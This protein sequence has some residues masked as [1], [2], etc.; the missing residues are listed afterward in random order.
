MLIF[1]Y[2]LYSLVQ[3]HEEVKTGSWNLQTAP[4]RHLTSS[5]V[6]L[7]KQ[8]FKGK[9]YMFPLHLIDQRFEIFLCKWP[10]KSICSALWALCHNCS[11][12]PLKQKSSY[13][14]Y[15]NKWAGSSNKI[16]FTKI[17]SQ[18]LGHSLLKPVIGH[19]KLRGSKIG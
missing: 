8:N 9:S 15:I 3:R 10:G 5:T 7:F 4:L 13:R 1:Q 2:A 19:Q 14:Q 17:D 11:T 16:L 6:L 12:L 18:L